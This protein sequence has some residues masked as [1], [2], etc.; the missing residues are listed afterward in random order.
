MHYLA[1]GG[2]CSVECMMKDLPNRAFAYLMAPNDRYKDF[3]NI[4]ND[5][6]ALLN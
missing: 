1:P 4:L 2:Y 5:L 3:I 6:C